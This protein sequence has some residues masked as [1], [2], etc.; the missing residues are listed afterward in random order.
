MKIE[1]RKIQ[2][3]LAMSEETTA[4]TADIYVDGK[5]AG[6]AKNHGHGGN[7]DYHA[8]EGKREL[9]AQAEKY[10]LSLPPLDLGTFKIEM[11]LENFIDELINKELERKEQKKF[12]KKME[13]HLM[14]GIPKSLSYVQVKFKK[15]LS[16]V[17]TLQLQSYVDKFK[18][19]FKE[20]EVFLN[21]NLE[22]LDIKL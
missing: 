6:Y 16:T 14:W 22:K 1:L 7:T 8:A 17:P 4:F 19:E 5:L 12:E 18:K 11:D 2:I 10:C 20:G 9:I 15:P 21:T 3:A 13:T